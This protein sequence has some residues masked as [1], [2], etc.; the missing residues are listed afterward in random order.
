MWGV[1]CQRSAGNGQEENAHPSHQGGNFSEAGG[2]RL[3]ARVRRVQIG[4]C[5]ALDCVDR[6][7]EKRAADEVE[8]NGCRFGQTGGKSSPQVASDDQYESC[9]G[10]E[11]TSHLWREAQLQVLKVSIDD[12]ESID[13]HKDP[14]EAPCSGK[15]LTSRQREELPEPPEVVGSGPK[16]CQYADR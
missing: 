9:L 12:R 14:P 16:E 10:A 5:G 11:A 7:P 15:P 13:R 4:V 8:A 2:L 6:G 3:A 1:Q